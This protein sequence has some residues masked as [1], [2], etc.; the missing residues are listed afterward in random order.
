M[1]KISDKVLTSPQFRPFVRSLFAVMRSLFFFLMMAAPFALL[2]QA[3]QKPGYFRTEDNPYYWK[4]NRPQP[5]YWQQDVHYRIEATLND[6]L[7][8]LEGRLTVHYFNNSPDALSE[9]YFHLYQNAF[10]PGSYY[11]ALWQGNGREPRFGE[12]HEVKGLGTVVEDIRVGR[13][14][15]SDT[16]LDNTLLRIR[17][18]NA[19]APGGQIQI[20]LKFTTHFG[21][22]QM[23]RRMK[24]YK[25]WGFKHY[26]AVHWYPILAVY[27][28]KMGWNRE[29]Q[30]LDKEFYANYGTFDVALTLPHDYIVGGSG[31]IQNRGEVLPE[32]LLQK[33]Q[34]TNFKDKP[35]GEAPSIIIPRLPGKTKT[36]R[37]RAENV[38]NFAF[39]AS[40]TYRLQETYTPAGQMVRVLAHE[41]NARGW[42]QSAGFQAYML[43]VYSQ[44]FGQYAWP[45]L[46]VADARDGMEYP[47]LTLCGGT[48]PGH[49]GLLAHESAHMW[50]YGML[51]SNEQYRAFM[52]EGFT[53]FAQVEAINAL[54]QGESR[55][56]TVGKQYIDNYKHP[57][58]NRYAD[59][60]YPYL[61]TVYS[62]FDYPLNTHSSDFRGAIRQGGGY[63]LVYFKTG[64]MLYQ[65]RYVLGEE[66]FW[67]AMQHYVDTWRFKHP[68]PEDFR[69]TIIQYTDTDLNWFFDQWLQTSKT[70][71]YAVQSV[72]PL[73]GN[74]Y[75]ITLKRKQDG[76]MPLELAIRTEGGDS[77]RY[78]IPNTWFEKETA[79]TTLPKWYGWGPTLNRTYTAEVALPSAPTQVILDPNRMLADIMAANIE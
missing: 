18:P 70:V 26:N 64:V 74:R 43:N 2:A 69:R 7:D 75:A 59:L 22:G 71:D 57:L 51:G 72:K 55:P 34:L 40:P 28:A 25:E 67:K 30:H 19:L 39:T 27:D 77:L 58:L 37:F 23:R 38:H 10:Q 42:Q 46:T 45:Q 8:R 5:G 21:D 47:M 73:G 33:I 50:F 12:K 36:W 29:H 76:Q 17:L 62:G 41:P 54:V 44:R 1:S 66:L 32:A 63:G 61:S 15:V 52:D 24:F 14:R 56:T 79:A 3:D 31:T 13:S 6:S 78:Y 53:Q 9:V 49:I 11:H 35:A 65:L 48:F 68:Y 60:F 20:S 16:T 4:N